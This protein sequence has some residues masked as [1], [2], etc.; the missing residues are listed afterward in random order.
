[1][2]PGCAVLRG[3]TTITYA[4]IIPALARLDTVPTTVA[5]PHSAS[6]G[7]LAKRCAG[8]GRTFEQRVLLSWRPRNYPFPRRNQNGERF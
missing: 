8:A 5:S 4:A 1:M 6:V 7:N 3:V 2:D